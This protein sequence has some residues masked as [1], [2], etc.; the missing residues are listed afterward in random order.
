MISNGKDTLDVLLAYMQRHALSCVLSKSDDF[1]G[2]NFSYHMYAVVKGRFAFQVYCHDTGNSVKAYILTDDKPY[3]IISATY[4]K[5]SGYSHNKDTFET[6]AW[7][8]ALKEVIEDFKREVSRHKEHTAK[9]QKHY[10]QVE[11]ESKQSH[12]AKAESYFK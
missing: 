2:C 5:Q 10:E 7:D 12:K 1:K 6:G 8:G 4:W 11:A 9:M 3:Q